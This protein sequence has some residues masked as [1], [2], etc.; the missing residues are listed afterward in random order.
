M[1]FHIGGDYKHYG[2]NIEKGGRKVVYNGGKNSNELTKEG[3]KKKIDKVHPHIKNSRLWFSV[4]KY[5]MWEHMC[6]EMDFEGACEILL[7]LYPNLTLDAKSMQ[8]LNV[9]SL[10]EEL[11]DWKF[12]Y[13]QPFKDE[14][15]FE[16]YKFVAIK[17]S[18]A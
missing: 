2:D 6:A 7:E 1:D 4:C 10:K 12:E 11:D 8:K 3:L 14:K 9:F 5:M 18:E 15:T 16:E 13:D 17:L